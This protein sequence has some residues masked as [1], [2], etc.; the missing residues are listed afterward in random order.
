M[1]FSELELRKMV[2]S[3]LKQLSVADEIKFNILNF[4][5]CIHN[6]KQDFIGSTYNSQYYG[7]L[8]MAFCKKPGS[9]FG[10]C[11]ANVKKE[12]LAL[13]YIFNEQGYELVEDIMKQEIR[14]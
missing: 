11:R 2:N 4:I 13:T 3:G 8:E 1:I 9:L 7:D 12:N 14:T 6:N 10:I 5:S